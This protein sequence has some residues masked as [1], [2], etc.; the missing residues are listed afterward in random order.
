MF[1][2]V[3]ASRKLAA[4]AALRLARNSALL[5]VSVKRGEPHLRA[6][7]DRLTSA[8]IRSN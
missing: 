3:V 4:A 7:L 8:P 6:E 1:S 2:M 5:G